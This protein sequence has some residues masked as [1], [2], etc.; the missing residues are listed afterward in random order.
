MQ[1]YYH[2]LLHNFMKCDDVVSIEPIDVTVGGAMTLRSRNQLPDL[3]ARDNDL[4]NSD[5][6][7]QL[8]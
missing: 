5:Q 3:I 1:L 7:E 6:D 2:P 4:S 8:R